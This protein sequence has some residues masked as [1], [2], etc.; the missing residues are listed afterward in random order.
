MPAMRRELV[1][2]V[3]AGLALWDPAV[4]EALAG[5]SLDEILRPREVLAAV[6]RSR[7]WD[8]LPENHD[9][10]RHEGM[11]DC[12]SGRDQVHSSVLARAGDTVSDNELERR[13]W[14]AQVGVL[15]PFVEGRRR[16]LLERL[17]GQLSGPFRF[18]DGLVVQDPRDLEI[19]Q[20]E[21]QLLR[22]GRKVPP[23]VRVLK[24]IRNRLAHL[25]V[26]GID[27]LQSSDLHKPL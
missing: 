18:D 17:D 3:I 20:I 23:L 7:G 22:R 16:E 10:C 19:G 26:V 2:S 12:F 27:L 1:V 9:A 11:V 6:A 5:L 8:S 15:L 13:V 14:S 4:S 21:Y 24:Q 25:E